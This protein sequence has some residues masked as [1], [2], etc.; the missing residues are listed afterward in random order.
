MQSWDDP[1]KRYFALKNEGVLLEAD[2]AM[3]TVLDKLQLYQHKITFT[4][5]GTQHPAGDFCARLAQAT[6]HGGRVCGIVL[7]VRRD[8]SLGDAEARWVTLRAR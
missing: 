6:V 5:E 1:H 8:G 4:V 7:E 3:H 2:A